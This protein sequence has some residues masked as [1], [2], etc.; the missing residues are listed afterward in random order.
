MPPF[1]MR[2]VLGLC[3]AVVLTTTAGVLWAGR[4]QASD[5]P[6]VVVSFSQ[7]PGLAATPVADAA[8]DA[9][10]AAAANETAT[11]LTAAG[12][13]GVAYGR[14]AAGKTSFG[15]SGFATRAEAQQ[16]GELYKQ[17]Y[18]AHLAEFDRAWQQTPVREVEATERGWA[19]MRCVEAARPG[20][21]FGKDE[22]ALNSEFAALDRGGDEAARRCMA[23][24]GTDIVKFTPLPR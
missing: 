22:A 8:I 12:L 16:A 2:L 17:C 21:T 23:A 7:P 10:Y 20:F 9:A 4:G 13:K 3:A 19:V 5:K 14:D 18:F 15:W 24:A 1:E 11:C 6:A